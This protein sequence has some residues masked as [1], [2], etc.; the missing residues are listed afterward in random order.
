MCSDTLCLASPLWCS[1]NHLN[2]SSRGRRYIGASC[3]IGRASSGMST[4]YDR[5]PSSMLIVYL[6]ATQ[7]RGPRRCF[8]IFIGSSTYRWPLCPN[9]SAFLWEYLRSAGRTSE[10]PRRSTIDSSRTR[11][12]LMAITTGS[13]FPLHRA[14]GYPATSAP[15]PS[16]RST[17]PITPTSNPPSA[18]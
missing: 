5:S 9:S 2:G 8:G 10:R 11:R 13:S 3:R 4:E 18:S 12:T 6:M 15:S 14:A 1:P 16:R 7:E 17:G